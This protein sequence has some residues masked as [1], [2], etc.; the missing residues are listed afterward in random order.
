[1]AG[2]ALTVAAAKAGAGEI[3]VCQGKIRRISQR[4]AIHMK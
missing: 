2:G 3:N 4:S 1:M